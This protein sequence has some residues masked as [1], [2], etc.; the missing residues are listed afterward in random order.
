MT[1]EKQRE[2]VTSYLSAQGYGEALRLYGSGNSEPCLE[3][4]RIDVV[5]EVAVLEG[6][7][8]VGAALLSLHDFDVLLRPVF[9]HHRS[10]DCPASC[11]RAVDVLLNGLEV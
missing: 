6:H 10:G 7:D 8:W 3:D 5:R 9:L 2:T 1:E 4:L 11:A